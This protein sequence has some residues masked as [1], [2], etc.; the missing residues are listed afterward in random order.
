[1]SGIHIE[2]DLRNALSDVDGIILLVNHQKLC[3]L[4]PDEMTSLTSTRILI[5]TVNGWSGR[6]WESAGFSMF[7]LGVNK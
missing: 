5:D 7:K 3:A 1:L 6:D 4:S 2:P